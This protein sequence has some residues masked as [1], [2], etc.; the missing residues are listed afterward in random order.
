[1]GNKCKTYDLICDN[2]EYYMLIRNITSNEL[3][4]SLNVKESVIDK[5]LKH[6]YTRLFTLKLAYDMSKVFEITMQELF[7][8]NVKS[9]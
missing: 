2:V 8:F 1:M 5:I 7:T 4:T 3:A 6:E 9:E